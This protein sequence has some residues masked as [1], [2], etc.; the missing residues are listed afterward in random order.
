VDEEIRRYPGE[1]ENQFIFRVCQHKDAIGSW[2]DVAD[3]L[4]NELGH[5]Y[6]ESTYRKKFEAFEIMY[7]ANINKLANT[8]AVDKLRQLKEEI[9]EER[10]KL[11]ALNLA[12]NRNLRQKSRIDLFCEQ[13]GDRLEAIPFEPLLEEIPAAKKMDDEWVLT[14]ADIHYGAK[15]QTATNEYSREEA[16]RRFSTLLGRV[17]QYALEQDIREM[18]VV[19]LGDTIQGLLRYTDLKLNEAPVVDC[20]VEVGGLIAGFLDGLSKV[21]RVNYYHVPTANHSQTRPLGSKASEIATEDLE[22]VVVAIITSALRD[23]GRVTV[24]SNSGND[25]IAFKVANFNCVATHGHTIKSVR[26]AIKDISTKDRMFYDYMFVGHYHDGGEI[27]AGEDE[28][29]NVEVLVCP[30]IVGTDP[31]ADSLLLGSKAAA[32]LFRFDKEFGHVGDELFILN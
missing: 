5:N 17:T 3:L 22:K 15:F 2:Q 19:C 6:S 24:S 10:Y 11:Q 31:Y 16:R 20:T 13:V 9:K 25:R 8:D 30:S 27:A 28:S 23:N 14:I 18:N 4:N 32:K 21:C 7:N 1:E 26:K 29:H 12:N